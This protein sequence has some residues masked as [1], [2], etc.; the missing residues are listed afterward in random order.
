MI[1]TIGS[2][3]IC[4]RHG[5][6]HSDAELVHA[7]ADTPI[8][9]K[10]RALWDAPP[11]KNHNPEAANG[12]TGVVELVG[13]CRHMDES[14]LERAGCGSC[15]AKWIYPCEI[16]GK[17]SPDGTHTGVKRC[18]RCVHRAGRNSERPEPN[19]DYLKLVN[20]HCP[21][22]VLVMSAAVESL[23]AT[24]PGQYVTA[25]KG[26]AA[27]I[28]EHNPN[29]VDAVSHIDGRPVPWREIKMQYPLIDKC[30]ER[31][32]HFM[33]GYCDYLADQI[34][35]PVPLVVNRPFVYLTDE[36]KGWLSQVAEVVGTSIPYWIVNAG[37]KS[38]YPAK[39][40]GWSNY[41]KLVDLL[42]GKVAF[43]QIGSEE[44]NHAPLSGLID[45]RGK[46]DTRQF[47]RLVYHAA[48]GVGPSTFLQ[49]ACAAFDKPYVCIAG[50]REPLA[51]QH[52]PRQATLSTIGVTPCSMSR[53]GRSCWK[54]RVTPDA[55]KPNSSVCELPT[56]SGGGELVAACV[57]S[58]R[59]E[60][61]AE[62]ILAR[63]NNRTRIS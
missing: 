16:Y 54:D 39:W 18:G 37:H 35:K 21:G 41:Q 58:I 52:Y 11:G 53:A 45:L 38:D 40:W 19:P 59:P 56:V 42:R 30:D 57:E 47:L 7:L 43:V 17:C 28:F 31:P 8:G 24:Y 2:D 32:V 10:F 63:F 15:Q 33:Q 36:E 34:G 13:P 48:G 4:Q 25:Y 3:G 26:T 50:G 6:K 62:E 23:H 44:H 20:E 5:R 46:T 27:A 9:E 55:T 22:D 51:W 61:V 1:C 60:R 49:H 29:V 12:G 14:P